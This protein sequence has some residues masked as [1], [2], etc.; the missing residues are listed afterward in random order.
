MLRCME[1]KPRSP[2][3]PLTQTI[4]PAVL[5][6][7][8]VLTISQLMLETDSMLVL[9]PFLYLINLWGLH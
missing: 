7:C 9:D 8:D 5:S 1:L 2:K 6:H 3:Y 4:S